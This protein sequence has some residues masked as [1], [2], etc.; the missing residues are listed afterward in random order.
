MQQCGPTSCAEHSS[1][2]DKRHEVYMSLYEGCDC[3]LWGSRVIPAVYRETV[4]EFHILAE[5]MYMYNVWW[6]GIS[7]DIANT[8]RY[9]SW[10]PI[11]T[12][13][14]SSCRATS[15]IWRW[16][17][18]PCACL[19]LDWSFSRKNDSHSDWHPL[20]T[21]SPHLKLS[22]MEELRPLYAKFGNHRVR[23]FSCIQRDQASHVCPLPP[24]V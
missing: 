16:P 5:W 13:T 21:E 14:Y 22:V 17:T 15:S 6:L 19:L 18:R 2:F 7:N 1:F 9:C 10:M 4:L 12:I 8:I 11:T 24:C 23:N 20:Q 3:L